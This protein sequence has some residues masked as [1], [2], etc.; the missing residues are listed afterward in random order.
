VKDDLYER[1][2]DLINRT[3]DRWLQSGNDVT[4]REVAD[5]VI[6]AA[7]RRGLLQELELEL[8]EQRIR[9][10]VSERMKKSSETTRNGHEQWSLPLDLGDSEKLPGSISFEKDIYDPFSKVPHK[11]VVYISLR[12]ATESKLAA[13][14]LLLKTQISNDS[15]RL[16]SIKE[17]HRSL[18]S[19][20]QAYPGIN[21]E[22]ACRI[23]KDERGDNSTQGKAEAQPD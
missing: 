6:A 10:M 16:Q 2:S 14:E 8:A 23:W 1:L 9:T 13:H 7:K 17:L 4:C 22:K 20:F 5:D 21:I 19:I 12:Y 3:R 15:A 18:R 11:E